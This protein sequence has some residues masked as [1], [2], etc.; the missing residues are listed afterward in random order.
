M[1]L[2]TNTKQEIVAHRNDTPT[3]HEFVAS[4]VQDSDMHTLPYGKYHVWTNRTN[5]QYSVQIDMGMFTVKAATGVRHNFYEMQC[6]FCN[7]NIYVTQEEYDRGNLFTVCR[8][9]LK[10]EVNKLAKSK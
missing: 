7:D 8:P 3:I 9:C 2:L 6:C 10:Q 5:K 4:S 1:M